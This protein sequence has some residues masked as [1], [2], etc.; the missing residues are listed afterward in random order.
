MRI[1]QKRFN[2]VYLAGK[3]PGGGINVRAVLS[4]RLLELVH[5][6]A[7]GRDIKSFLFLFVRFCIAYYLCDVTAECHSQAPPSLF[8]LLH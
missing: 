7:G 1:L 4:L 2:H 8:R 5:T 6:S 3:Q